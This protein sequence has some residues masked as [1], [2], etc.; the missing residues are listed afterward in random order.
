MNK[1]KELANKRID[2]LYLVVVEIVIG[3]LLITIYKELSSRQFLKLLD[4]LTWPI[5]VL[6]IFYFFKKLSAY[7]FLSLSGFN[8]F[9]VKGEFKS[10]REVIK[11]EAGKIVKQQKEKEEI[12][13]LIGQYAK[14]AKDFSELGDEKSGIIKDYSTKYKELFNKYEEL[15]K[16]YLEY[17]EKEIVGKKEILKKLEDKSNKK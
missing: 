6:L 5:V 1:I 12:N 14:I 2:L 16:K 13:V 4:I 3:L 9:G 7:L 8:I 11:E 10:P 17:V 15:S